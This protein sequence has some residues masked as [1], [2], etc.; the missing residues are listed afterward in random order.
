MQKIFYNL[1]GEMQNILYLCGTKEVTNDYNGKNTKKMTDSKPRQEI[2]VPRG[3]KQKLA[4][5][6]GCSLNMIILYL[7]GVYDTERAAIVR[8]EALNKYN[9]N[10]RR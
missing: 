8:N 10:Y 2:M 9:G 3:V 1:L 6:L 4:T 5:E 7:R